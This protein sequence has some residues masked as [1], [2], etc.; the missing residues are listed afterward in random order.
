[1]LI[2]SENTI[3]NKILNF[4]TLSEKE[5]W[6]KGS[7]KTF[8]I[9]MRILEFIYGLFYKKSENQENYYQFVP[10]FVSL[11]RMEFD[12]LS[13]EEQVKFWTLLIEKYNNVKICALNRSKK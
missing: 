5:E 4:D 13:D 2:S 12:Y 7:E 6:V 10:L 8:P 9:S 11:Y 1:M 3:D